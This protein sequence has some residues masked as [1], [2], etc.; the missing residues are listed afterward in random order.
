MSI[1]FLHTVIANDGLVASSAL[2]KELH[3]T[4][5][6]LAEVTGLSRGS[7]KDVI[8]KQK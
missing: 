1:D 5:S 2:A 3:I 6:D 7:W 8:S 4:K